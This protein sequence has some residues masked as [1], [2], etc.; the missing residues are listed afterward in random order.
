L[1]LCLGEFDEERLPESKRKPLIEMLL[2]V[3]RTDP[4]PG[5]HAAAEWLLRKWGQGEK[6]ATIDKELRQNEEQLA[7][8]QDNKRQ[9]Y[10]NSQGQ[11]FVILHAGEFRMGSPDSEAG[12]IEHLHRRKIG[13]RFAIST[14]EVT[15]AQWRVFAN[16]H[17]GNV[18]P[19]DQ[20]EQR[21]YIRTDDSPMMN[22]TWYEA[23]WY[24][25]WLSEQEGI[26]KAQWCYEVN[27]QKEYGPGMKTKENFLELTGYRLP[28][29]AEWE[30]A[31]R[32]EARTSWYYGRSETMLSQYA[33]YQANSENHAWP[34]GSLKP[35]EFGLFD[36]HGNAVEWCYD[37]FKYYPAD[38]DEAAEDVAGNA[39]VSE[40]ARRVL[41]GGAFNTEARNVRSAQRSLFHPDTRSHFTGFR[42]ARTYH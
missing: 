28:T 8:E 40:T 27:D 5:L 1:L 37:A 15:K 30:F 12:P 2:T 16:S 32:A 41:R 36:M 20:E 42:A 6:I 11:T 14:K 23:A 13:R 39:S 22:M 35:N 31:C 25:N 3:Y 19:P 24:C 34:V 4:D 29:E 17:R 33:W 10:I 26:P 21:P 38:F 7:A 9:W 18:L